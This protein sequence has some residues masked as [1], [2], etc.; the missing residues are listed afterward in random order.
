MIL[1]EGVN[2]ACGLL[3]TWWRCRTQLSAYS[4]ASA[5]NLPLGDGTQLPVP[6]PAMDRGDQ[7]QIQIVLRDGQ[8]VLGPFA[9]WGSPSTCCPR[10]WRDPQLLKRIADGRKLRTGTDFVLEDATAATAHTSA[11]GTITGLGSQE[12]HGLGYSTD[13]A[14][15][16]IRGVSALGR[17]RIDDGGE[18]TSR[19]FYRSSS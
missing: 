9:L 12:G 11:S 3:V 19:E 2:V 7:N 5:E 8:G 15:S 13:P 1:A 4:S 14:P 6:C 18:C 10:L 16:I 17:G